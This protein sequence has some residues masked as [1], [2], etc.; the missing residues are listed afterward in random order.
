LTAALR[1]SQRLHLRRR[2]LP[3]SFIRCSLMKLSALDSFQP[4]GSQRSKYWMSLL[5][6]LVKVIVSV[7]ETRGV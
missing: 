1:E 4:C 7:F 5:E 6:E 2:Q 3:I